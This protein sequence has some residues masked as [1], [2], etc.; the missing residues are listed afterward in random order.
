MRMKAAIAK[1]Y[2]DLDIFSPLKGLKTPRS[3]EKR[4]MT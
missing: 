1:L 2:R 4:S 3:K